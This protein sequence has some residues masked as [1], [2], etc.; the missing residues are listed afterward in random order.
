VGES[1]FLG[2]DFKKE[3]RRNLG[4]PLQAMQRGHSYL[5]SVQH[6]SGMLLYSLPFWS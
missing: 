5:L 4:H 3:C 6:Y 2:F 1:A